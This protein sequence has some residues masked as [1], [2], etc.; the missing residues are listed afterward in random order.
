MS[1]RAIAWNA[2]KVIVSLAALDA[3]GWEANRAITI[4]AFGAIY[5]RWPWM[6]R[7]S[8]TSSALCE[9]HYMLR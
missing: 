1:R 6:P 3:T 9:T 5:K 2:G 7:A 8:K 4:S